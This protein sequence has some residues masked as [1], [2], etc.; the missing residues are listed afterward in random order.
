MGVPVLRQPEKGN[1]V[2]PGCALVLSLFTT[3]HACAS[4]LQGIYCIYSNRSR[5]P[6]SSHPRIVAARMREHN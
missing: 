6:I 4:Y 1:I 2:T 5:I 3:K